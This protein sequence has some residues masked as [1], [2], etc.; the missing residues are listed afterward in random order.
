MRRVE[1]IVVIRSEVGVVARRDVD[2]VFVVRI[3]VVVLGFDNLPVFVFNN[4]DTFCVYAVVDVYCS[5]LGVASAQDKA[6]QQ[7]Q[8]GRKCCV[9]FHVRI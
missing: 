2:I 3:F 9:L 1:R 6:H 7:N 4:G 5:Q 8:R